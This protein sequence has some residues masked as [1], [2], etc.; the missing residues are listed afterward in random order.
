VDALAVGSLLLPVRVYLV[1][2]YSLNA[3]GSPESPYLLCVDSAGSL[4][5]QRVIDTTVDQTLNAMGRG[6][7]GALALAGEAEDASTG[8]ADGALLAANYLAESQAVSGTVTDHDI[9]AQDV[10]GTVTVL[11]AGVENTGGGGADALV[12]SYFTNGL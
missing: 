11:D 4:Q 2:N 5:W 12:L 8:W 7:M 9:S 6:Y 10:S 3:A 1:G